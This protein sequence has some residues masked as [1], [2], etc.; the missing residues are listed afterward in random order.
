MLKWIRH[1]WIVGLVALLWLPMACTAEQAADDT[2][3]SGTHYKTL[4]RSVPTTAKEGTVEVAEFF[5]YSCPHCFRFEPTV[6]QWS[7]NPPAGVTFKTI[8]A[9]FGPNAELHAKAHYTAINLDVY[10]P[11]HKAMFNA[12]HKQGRQLNNEAAIEQIFVE[13]GVKA[14]DFKKAFGSFNVDNQVRRGEVLGQAYAVAGVPALAVAGKY[15]ITAAMA[16]GFE[17]ML[18]IA[19]FLVNKELGK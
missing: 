10:E 9:S 4:A 3:V 15:W 1:Q 11:V 18:E 12:I 7:T 13:N 5:L 19:E 2:Y 17:E 6:G 16:G 14:E 8:P